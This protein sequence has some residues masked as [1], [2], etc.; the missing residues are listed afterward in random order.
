MSDDKT[1]DAVQ[2]VK[3]SQF[4][5]VGPDPANK[6]QV[7]GLQ[8]DDNVRADLTTDLVAT[9]SSVVFRDSKGRFKSRADVP[10]LNNQ[11][12]VN[13]F[14]WEQ[15]EKLLEGPEVP[16]LPEERLPIFAEDE[17]TEYPH[18]ADGEPTDLQVEDQWYQVTDPNFDYDNPDPEGLDLYIWTETSTDTFEWVL[19]VAEIPD[20]AVIIKGEAPDQEEDQVGNGSLWFDNS[21]DTMQLYVW[22]EESG[23]WIPVAPPS[24]LE[25]RVAVGEATQQAIIDQIQESL[26]EQETIK[27]KVNALEGVVGEHSLTFTTTNAN[28]RHGEF[29]LK[30][31]GMQMTN[32]VSSAQ[33]ISMTDTDGA[34]NT[35]DLDRITEG[36]VLRFSSVDGQVAELRITDGT[37]GVFTFTKISGDLDRLS[38]MPY[39]FILLSSFDPAGLA[40]IDYVDAQDKALDEKIAAISAPAAGGSGPLLWKYNPSVPADQLG[41]GEF[42]LSS[43]LDSGSASEW[44]IYFAERDPNGNRWFPHNDGN[45]YSHTVDAQFATIR[46]KASIIC[47][48]KTRKLYFNEGPNN[49]ASLKLTY[50]RKEAALISGK[51]YLISVPGYMPLFPY[52][53]DAYN[54]G[55]HS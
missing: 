11:L 12:E 19:F 29:N 1:R 30:D 33:Y 28:P 42:R 45:S 41:N 13:R 43:G 44:T 18:A 38:E 37:N 16:E 40:T 20:G 47:H 34:G 36:D 6:L 53:D 4:K 14:L 32:M 48:G 21:E 49:H 10:E 31:G 8:Q 46:S 15:I 27:N 2:G 50:Y 5:K 54:N 26:V 22:H 55:T 9:N 35:I 7:V 23:A 3:F 17:P 52:S 39:Q 25:G 24:T 51:Y